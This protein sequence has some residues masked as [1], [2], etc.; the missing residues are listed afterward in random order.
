MLLFNTGTKRRWLKLF[1]RRR[2]RVEELGHQADKNIERHVLR[3]LERLVSVRRFVATWVLLFV[4]LFFSTF[5][6]I[7]GLSSY[8]QVLRPVPGGMYSEGLVGSF[9]NAN[10]LYAAGAADTAVSRLIFSGLFKHDSNN[11]LV[12][13][14]ADSWSVDQKQAR[15]VVTLKH[16][17]KWHDG[18][19]FTAD[20]V[21][22][23]YQTIQNPDARSA[24][25]SNW[26]GI[27]V[28]KQ[29]A[30]VVSFDL[31]NAMSSFPHALT[32]G[33]VPKHLLKSIPAY[34]LRSASFNTAPVGT[35]PFQWKFVEVTGSNPESRE[36]SI[37]L[38]P[39]AVYH[40]G[41]PKLD[42]FTLRTFNDEKKLTEAF[43]DK[44]LNAMS[45][46]AE[47]PEEL[48]KKHQA[49]EY[50]TPL[51]SAVMAFFNTSRD[52]LNDSKVR[53]A[54]VGSVDR[55][56]IISLVNY[57]GSL[58]QG[59]LLRGQLGYDS[60]IK[61]VDYN[62]AAANSLLDSAGWAR[63][64]SGQR[65]KAGQPLAFTLLSQS[66]RDYTIVTQFLQKAWSQLGI[67]VEVRYFS[68]DDIQSN[69]IASHEYDVLLYGI[70]IGEDPDVF[71][72]WH[73]SQAS[74]GSQGHLNLS[75]YKSAA[76]DQA[77]EAGRTR[78]D[79]ALRAVKYKPF[80]QAWVA[81][82]PAL[83]LYQPKY[84]YITRGPV[85]GYQKKVINSGVDRFNNVHQWMVREQK[86]N[87]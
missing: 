34:E 26:Q 53:Q 79:P 11:Q 81:D 74:I 32:N 57:P 72:F 52:V 28:I 41:R 78:A 4:L 87:I 80:L 23:T 7:R 8:Y 27:K 54:L 30:L 45:G 48:I 64:A 3:R 46:L 56:Q 37:T 2:Q 20:D 55:H 13:D 75:E 63:N 29:D 21:V 40:Y 73:S 10:P 43:E 70:N 31:P 24:L 62:L 67:K 22:F 33:I 66:T 83:A 25:Y 12:S 35:G 49:R 15:Y 51:T 61:E 18:R 5:A 16:N 76:A 86:Q 60:S 84:L 82:A 9:T 39:N 59:P 19:P 47:V 65:V 71:A 68:A 14:L 69:V 50:V 44:E 42:G 58:L 85:Y 38:A 6:Q 1:R 17:I 36:Q 77:L